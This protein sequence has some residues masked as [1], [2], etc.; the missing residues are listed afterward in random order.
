MIQTWLQGCQE[1]LQ[2]LLSSVNNKGM[3][4][5]MDKLLN[6]LRIPANLVQYN[7]DNGEFE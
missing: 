5:D 4:M 6:E 2:E 7:T 1:A 3:N